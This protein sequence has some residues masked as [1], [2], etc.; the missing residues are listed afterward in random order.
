MSR[1]STTHWKKTRQKELRK[2]QRL[3]ITHCKY[4]NNKLNYHQSQTPTSAEVDHI[5]G[6]TNTGN[7]GHYQVIC[8]RCNQSKGNRKTPKTTTLQTHKPLTTSRNW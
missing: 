1:T 3:G 4:C 7:D 2:A 8:R 6:Y 5:N